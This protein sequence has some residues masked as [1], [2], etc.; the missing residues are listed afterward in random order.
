MNVSVLIFFLDYHII[1]N[2]IHLV[3][4][5]T[6]LTLLTFRPY[7]MYIKIQ[8]QIITYIFNYFM[9]LSVSIGI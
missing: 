1:V 4:S 9:I 8:K 5:K 6:K 2:I 3:N 7:T